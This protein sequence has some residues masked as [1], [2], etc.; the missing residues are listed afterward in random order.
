MKL[1]ILAGG[2]GTRLKTVISDTPKALAPVC[3]VPFLQLQLEHWIAHARAMAI[4][5]RSKES[6]S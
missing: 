3:S 2:F 5:K 1:L 4:E 6:F